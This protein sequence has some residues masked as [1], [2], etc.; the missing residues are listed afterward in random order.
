LTLDDTEYN[1]YLKNIPVEKTHNG[2]FAVD[3]K[4]KYVNPSIQK[5]G[6]TKGESNDADA[7]DLILRDK[8]RLLSFEEPVRFIFSHSALREG[9][10]NPNVF[11]ICQLKN[12]NYDNIIT[13]R[14]ELGRGL[15]L[16]VNQSGERMDSPL[17]VHQI[18]VLTVVANE[19]YKDFVKALLKETSDSLSARPKSADEDYFKGK[20]IKT[21]DGTLKVD[22]KM[23]KQ[24]YR[25]LVKNDYT[26]DSDMIVDA[27]HEAKRE[28]TL[29]DFNDELKPY[30]EE[31]HQL[32]S[33]VFSASLLPSIE[34]GRKRRISSELSP[35]VDKV[36]PPTSYSL[37]LFFCFFVFLGLDTL[38]LYIPIF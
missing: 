17:N 10:D 27:Y 11:N 30:A 20:T 25:Y 18:N 14:Q 9:W 28:G 15:R 35:K 19:S 29:A 34:D 37:S 3:K 32:I 23:A 38:L 21:E 13:R 8:E 7:Y 24:I 5:S 12:L 36:M 33:G 16:A 6:E 31:I 2:Y 26:D 1:R 22:D 4:K